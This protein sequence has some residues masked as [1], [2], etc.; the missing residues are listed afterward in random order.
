M[1]TE[2]LVFRAGASQR[3]GRVEDGTTV[4]D[5][6][7]EEIK[8]HIST[9]IGLCEFDYKG[10]RLNLLDT[11]G[12]ADF[13]TEAQEAVRVAD[14]AFLA[15][16]AGAGIEVQTPRFWG[17]CE[18]QHIPVA[19]LINKV[20]LEN[21]DFDA[22]VAELQDAFGHKVA[23]LTIPIVSGPTTSRRALPSRKLL[24][25]RMTPSWRSILGE[26]L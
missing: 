15:I 3:V 9:S 22:R 14:A 8:R 5:Y 12:Y 24:Q 1:I 4:S 10:V 20:D 26:K 13:M 2:R 17:L 16:N 18:A 25:N 11:P 7:D 19:F 6:L 23:T 21:I